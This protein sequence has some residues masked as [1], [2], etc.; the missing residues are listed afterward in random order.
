MITRPQKDPPPS[1]A[2]AGN[3]EVVD[4]RSTCRFGVRDKLVT[5]VR[6]SLPVLRGEAEVSESGILRTA[7]VELS[8]DGVDTGNAHRDRDLHKAR[9]LDAANHPTIR[10]QV[11]NATLTESGWAT[12][13]VVGARGA[14]APV[15]LTIG[16][17]TANDDEVRVTAIGRLDRTPLGIKVPTL[18][19]GRYVDL[20]AVLTFRRS[21]S[22][23]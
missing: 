8:A 18:I 23:A 11:V 9:F 22:T 10:V 15:D 21:P 14:S 20:D 19:V 5:N 12:R 4:A 13:A 3:W 2:L 1:P 16:A 17:Q 7:Y 6:G